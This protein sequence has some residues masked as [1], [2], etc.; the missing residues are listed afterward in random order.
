MVRIP[1]AVLKFQVTLTLKAVSSTLRDSAAPS[2]RAVMVNVAIVRVVLSGSVIL[3][4]VPCIN[5]TRPNCSGYSTEA[6][7]PGPA[8]FRSNSGGS[9]VGTTVTVVCA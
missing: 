1:V 3:C 8:L 6:P 7:R 5:L 2:G 9:F 4:A